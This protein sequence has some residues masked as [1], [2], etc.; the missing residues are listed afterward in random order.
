MPHVL[1]WPRDVAGHFA[2]KTAIITGG[3]SGIGRALGAALATAGARV[4]LADIDGEAATTAANA[5]GASANDGAVTGRA[6]DV[7]DANA[8]Q[9]V[10]DDVVDR[11]GRL[12]LYFN[13]AGI[14]MGGP[15]HELTTAHWERIID[16]NVRG[17][18]NGVVAA[19]PRM[20]EQGH[21]HL[22]NTASGAGLA[23][24]PLVVPYAT[25]KHAVVGLSTGLR[26]EA[27]LRG[28]RVSVLCP[29]AVETAILD[30]RPPRDLPPTA[31]EPVTARR[32]LTA[33]GQ[34]PMAAGVFARRALIDV[35]RNRSIIVVP[36]MAKS[37]WYLQRLSPSV[38][39]TLG[40][41][42]ARRI[43]RDLLRPSTNRTP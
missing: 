1:P 14:S 40:R 21:G 9:S 13:N 16:V 32:Y 17:V 27:A 24:P 35:A 3:A 41:V 20:V 37:L 11:H 28:V 5:M 29:G 39:D 26:P 8:V 33:L 38:V 12:D 19:Y 36:R 42:I 22:V 31:S 43:E 7:R 23:A 4:V 6:V 15:T 30:L 25:T 18:V 34:Q 2:G 10:V